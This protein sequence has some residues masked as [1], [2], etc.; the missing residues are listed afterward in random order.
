MVVWSYLFCLLVC[1][2]QVASLAYVVFCCSSP[3]DGSYSPN[4]FVVG[5]DALCTY[6]VVLGRRPETRWV[7]LIF[8]LLGVLSKIVVLFAAEDAFLRSLPLYA[9]NMWVNRQEMNFND[10]SL[11]HFDYRIEI[12]IGSTCLILWPGNDLGSAK[13]SSLGCSRCNL[14]LPVKHYNA[15]NSI[16]SS[17]NQSIIDA[18]ISTVTT[19]VFS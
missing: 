19:E 13:P 3:W 17:S 9:L 15:T 4:E 14:I 5:G 6:M 8:D 2:E 12:L 10:R 18:F 7:E 1:L 11:Q 16:L